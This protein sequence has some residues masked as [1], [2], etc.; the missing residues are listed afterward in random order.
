MFDTNDFVESVIEKGWGLDEVVEEAREEIDQTES[1][2]RLDIRAS[3]NGAIGTDD[4]VRFLRS[5]VFFLVSE[6]KV[7]PANL[8]ID[9]FQLLRPLA[10][11]LV[12][13]GDLKP[14]I[15]ELFGPGG[16]ATRTAISSTIERRN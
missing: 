7:R 3:A 1:C 2:S 5:M 12:N 6:S 11:H 13:R 15:L 10:Q 16:S 9:D 4:H 8:S 14:Y